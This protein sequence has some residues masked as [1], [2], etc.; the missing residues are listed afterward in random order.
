MKILGI[1]FSRNSVVRTEQQAYSTPFGQIGDGNLSLPFIQ[2][3][4]HKA[5]VIYFGQDNLFPSVLDQMY[6]TSPIHGAVIDFTVMAVIGG[7]FTVDG[8]TDGKDKVAFGVWSRRNK[9]D[10]NLETVARDYKMHAR[11]HFLLHY[12][13]SGKFLFM[14][15]LQPASIRYRFDGNY[16]FSSDWSTGKERRFL[17]AY[18]PAKVGKYKEMLYTFGEVGAGQD[19]YPI[20]TYSS[21][22]NWCYLDGE[23][24]YFHKSNLQNSIF[25]SL[26]IRRPK[27]FGSKKEVEDF[28]DGLMNN[29]GA[30][31]AGKVF[32]LTGDGME[33]T[34]EVVTPSAQNNDKLFEGTSKEL[35]D[36]ICFAH[37]INP[38]IMGVKVAGSLG[39]AQ[40]LEMS[41]AIFEKNVVFPMRRQL[42]N[43]YNELLQIANVNGTFN[44]TGFK[45]IGEEIVG[46]EE[47]KINKTGELLNAMSPLLAN[48]VLDNL[49]INEI[50]RIAGLADVPDGDKLANPSAPSNNPETPII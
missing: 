14:E 33:N 21:A 40:E 47:S 27:R 8:L 35:K 37:K 7:G 3:Q 4:V 2:S 45:I 10:R 36:N 11:V 49:T 50:R 12:S 48:K 24:S 16:E 43:M 29:K 26:I 13:D 17:E 32:V 18:H 20:P 15:R 5:G 28:K 34:P 46:G 41:Y 38:S 6:Y 1:N 44:I 30:K 9:V 19:I 31:N 25:P 42:E 39:N 22:L 23:Q